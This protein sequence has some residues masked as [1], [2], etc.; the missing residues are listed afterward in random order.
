[1]AELKTRPSDASVDRF[2][3]SLPEEHRRQDC[4]KLVE[5]M[6][7]ATGAQPRM[8]GSSI[9]GFGEYHYVYAS[10]REG[11]WFEVGF[12]PRKQNLTLYLMA[13]FDGRETLLRKLGKHRTG[14][15]CLYLNRLDDVHMPTLRQLIVQSVKALRRPRPS[16]R[17]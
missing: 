2:I 4:C 1:M 15:G 10:G 12:S 11:D 8:W 13:G 17:H 5:L 7:S 3:Q 14:K 16:R 9:V 6:R